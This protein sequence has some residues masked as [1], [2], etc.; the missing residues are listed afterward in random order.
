MIGGGTVGSGVFHALERNGGLM[1]S[2]IGV[3]L[4][5]LKVAVKAFDE[6]RP[7]V[8]PRPLL[9]TDWQEVVK[10]PR[11]NIVVELVGGTTI[12][13]TMILE[14]LK[15]SLV[16]HRDRPPATATR[17]GARCSA[18]SRA[19]GTPPRARASARP[20]TPRGTC[21]GVRGS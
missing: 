21:A 1:A 4:N 11:V 17:R 12:A 19:R 7:Y 15:L 2:R 5:M 18:V 20:R 13:R 8:I 16:G 10:D 3:S 6:P 9:T 14:A